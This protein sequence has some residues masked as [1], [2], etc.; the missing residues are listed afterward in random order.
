MQLSHLKGALQKGFWTAEQMYAGVFVKIFSIHAHLLDY[1]ILLN[2]HL[3]TFLS[4]WRL[5]SFK[6]SGTLLGKNNCY[7]YQ[8]MQ[9]NHWQGTKKHFF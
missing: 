2:T 1:L 5:I 4:W 3:I 8:M 7:C 6:S 9:T